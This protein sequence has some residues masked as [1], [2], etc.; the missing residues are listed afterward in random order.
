MVVFLPLI[1]TLGILY[2]SCISEEKKLCDIE[3]N[4]S[5]FRLSWS[6]PIFKLIAAYKFVKPSFIMMSGDN[7]IRN[8]YN[9]FLCN[10]YLFWAY[11]IAALIEMRKLQKKII[12]LMSLLKE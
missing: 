9:L 7:N 1:C 5:D 6:L 10:G 12:L 4:P 8:L 2:L 3:D 11:S